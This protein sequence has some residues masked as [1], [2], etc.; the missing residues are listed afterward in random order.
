MVPSL[1]KGYYTDIVFQHGFV[2]RKKKMARASVSSKRKMKTLAENDNRKPAAADTMPSKS[3]TRPPSFPFENLNGSLQRHVLSFAD[4]PDLGRQVCVNRAMNLLAN[5]DSLWFP[6]VKFLLHE[7]FGSEAGT[8]ITD[9]DWMRSSFL[10]NWGWTMVE[11]WLPDWGCRFHCKQTTAKLVDILVQMDTVVP[12]WMMVQDIQ[13]GI[14]LKARDYY[15]EV[16]ILAM[17]GI[18]RAV[19]TTY[20]E[21]GLENLPSIRLL[22]LTK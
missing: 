6:H 11:G 19:E 4:V 20:E 2:P 3:V 7:I 12:D 22:Q 5:E 8:P 18:E 10:W 17:Q 21:T 16:G 14:D 13:P 9:P 1:K 15:K